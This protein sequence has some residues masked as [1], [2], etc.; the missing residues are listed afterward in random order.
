MEQHC[1]V[2]QLKVKQVIP[3]LTQSLTCTSVP[4]PFSG[5][6]LPQHTYMTSFLTDF[7]QVRETSS[8]ACQGSK[9]SHRQQLL[10]LI[11]RGPCILVYSYNKSQW[12]A[13]FL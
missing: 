10:N 12:D 4:L 13:L 6:P 11:F 3:P 7:P 1:P 2:H 5:G 8:E 9:Q